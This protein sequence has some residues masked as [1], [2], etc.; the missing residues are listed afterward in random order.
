MTEI[1]I[2]E[3]ATLIFRKMQEQLCTAVEQL[4]PTARFREDRWDRETAAGTQG[5]GGISRVLEGGQI[6][7]KAGMNFS[8][9]HGKLIPEMSKILVGI[10]TELPFYA[11]GASLVF[12]PL[13]PHVPAVHAN[14]R[15]IEAG[16]KAWVGG[17][18]DLTP[19]YLVED[20]CVHFHQTLKACCDRFSKDYYARFKKWCDQYF[21]LPHR[22]ETRGIGGIFF[23]YLGREDADNLISYLDFV[24]AIPETFEN[25]YFPIV[26]RRMEL[27]FTKEQ[28]HFQAIRR[29]RYA[30][31]NLLYDRGTHFGFKT[32]GRTESILMSMP[33]LASWVYDYQAPPESAEERMIQVLKAPREWVA[34]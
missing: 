24:A 16:Q 25:A 27:P 11:S 23:D 28:K 3:R 22:G 13:S 8:A 19:S 15:Y 30:E 17:G 32:K 34:E 31:F 7:E 26:R 21:Y 6:F 4:E 20:D 12:H 9:V 5:G 33:P 14:I 29:S 18:T 10:E 1:H 2:R